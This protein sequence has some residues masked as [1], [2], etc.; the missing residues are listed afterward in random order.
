MTAGKPKNK[1]S[2]VDVMNT[3]NYRALENA[4]KQAPRRSARCRQKKGAKSQSSSENAR[5]VISLAMEQNE[6]AKSDIT[7][8]NQNLT[9]RKRERNNYYSRVKYLNACN[10]IKNAQE[11]ENGGKT[12][13]AVTDDCEKDKS[14]CC[15]RMSNLKINRRDLKNPETEMT[16]HN[17][18]P[19]KKKQKT[20]HT[21][22][23]KTRKNISESET[24]II[25]DLGKVKSPSKRKASQDVNESPQKRQKTKLDHSTKK[26]G[27]S[28]V[29]GT[30]DHCP[31]LTTKPQDSL[32]LLEDDNKVKD[33]GNDKKAVDKQRMKMKDTMD[34]DSDSD[35]EWEEVEG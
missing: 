20:F 4:K 25:P 8:T 9:S 12:E 3:C 34:S 11:P 15:E 5:E 2:G 29:S 6:N 16:S 26:L 19:L 10:N 13:T 31:K 28:V 27:E 22:N 18:L 30:T 17:L 1:K 23:G 21:K 35:V 14:N 32:L 24:V 33:L 7:N